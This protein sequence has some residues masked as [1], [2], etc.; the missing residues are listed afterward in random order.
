MQVGPA[1]VSAKQR[2]VLSTFP[3]GSIANGASM[4]AAERKLH[5]PWLTWAP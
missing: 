5:S 3:R 2:V 4:D 1:Q